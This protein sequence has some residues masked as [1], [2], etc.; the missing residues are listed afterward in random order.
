MATLLDLDDGQSGEFKNIALK[1]KTAHRLSAMGI[2]VGAT[3]IRV[4]TAPFGDPIIYKVGTTVVAMRK[5]DSSGVE[6]LL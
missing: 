4:R 2:R 3:I 5:S 6:I 1:D